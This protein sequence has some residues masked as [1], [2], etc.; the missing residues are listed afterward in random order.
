MS[1]Y[2]SKYYLKKEID[3]IMSNLYQIDKRYELFKCLCS[4]ECYELICPKI[5]NTMR[6][7]LDSL[8]DNT[9]IGLWKLICDEKEKSATIYDVIKLYKSNKDFFKEKK[10]YYAIDIN[11][12]KRV[13]INFKYKDVKKSI[14]KLED[15][16]KNNKDVI[17]FVRKYRNKSLAHNDKKF[18]FDRKNKYSNVKILYTDIENLIKILIEDMNVISRDVFGCTHGFIHKESKELDYVCHLLK[19]NKK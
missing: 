17:N 8:F 1:K 11:T 15:D 9:I 13:R 10:Y 7:V 12:G 18:K 3:V 5:P 4:G 14:K 2:S 6:V 19:N 16:L